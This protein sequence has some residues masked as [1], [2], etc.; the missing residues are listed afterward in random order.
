MLSKLW[1]RVTGADKRKQYPDQQ[2]AFL[3]RV[4]ECAIVSPYGLYADLPSDCLLLEVARGVAIPVTVQRPSDTE[5]GEPTLFHPMTNTRIVL[6][7]NGDLDIK[8]LDGAGSVNIEAVDVNLTAT[9]DVVA[10]VAGALSATVGGSA[11]IDTPETILTGNVT[12]GGNLQVDGDFNND[13]TA[14]LGGAGGKPIARKDDA[15]DGSKIIA[16]SGT[17]TAT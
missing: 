11:T 16:G 14:T 7:N 1:G 8:A 3:G 17:H 10:D 4:G 12:V 9:G 6:R 13:G 2:A 5:Q 15:T